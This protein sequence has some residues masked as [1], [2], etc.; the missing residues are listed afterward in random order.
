MSY[1]IELLKKQLNTNDY[2]WLRN[3]L[4]KQLLEFQEVI[5]ENELKFFDKAHS[6]ISNLIGVGKGSTP[7][8]DDIFL[9]IIIALYCKEPELRAKL[10]NLATFPFEKLTSRKSSSLIR[11]FLRYNFPDEIAT[12]IELLNLDSLTLNQS[13][14]FNAELQKIKLIGASS[15]RYLLLGV[16]WQL[17]YYEIRNKNLKV[18]GEKYIG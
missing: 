15:G 4:E 3:N 12:F 1:Q 5:R 7:Q 8:S 17:E 14:K 10:T 2:D 9:G 18:K 13:L 11:S 16:L 6:I